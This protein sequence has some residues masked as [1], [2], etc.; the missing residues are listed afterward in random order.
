LSDSC[1]RRSGCNPPQPSRWTHAATPSN[2]GPCPSSPIWL[3]GRG[4]PTAWPPQLRSACCRHGNAGC[5]GS[6]S[7]RASN[8]SR[9]A[10]SD[11]VVRLFAWALAMPHG[12]AVGVARATIWR[13]ETLSDDGFGDPSELSE[14]I[15]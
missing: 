15:G 3:L 2:P 13:E 14:V 4:P 1:S 7:R 5:C 9:T 11:S 12:G 8:R 6:R 10:R